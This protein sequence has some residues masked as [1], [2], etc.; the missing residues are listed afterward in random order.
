LEEY[1]TILFEIA[2]SFICFGQF[3][4]TFHLR[5]LPSGFSSR[6]ELKRFVDPFWVLFTFQ[7]GKTKEERRDRAPA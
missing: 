2:K 6:A 1:V 7:T 4:F 3:F 5:I